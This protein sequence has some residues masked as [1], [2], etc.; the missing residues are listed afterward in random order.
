MTKK[1]YAF[2]TISIE[3][4]SDD[5]KNRPLTNFVVFG[6][7][8]IQVEAPTQA[9]HLTLAYHFPAPQFSQLEHLV[10]AIDPSC[11]GEWE[12]RLFSRDIRQADKEVQLVLF[13]HFPLH[14]TL[15]F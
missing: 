6:G 14:W 2:L 8:D 7:V 9:L 11:Q 5:V 1:T 13:I 12:L 10:K 3:L 4:H 15:T